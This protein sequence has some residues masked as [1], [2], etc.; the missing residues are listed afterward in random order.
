MQR[1]LQER[2]LYA[3]Q[4]DGVNGPQTR[5]AIRAFQLDQLDLDTPA[6]TV[7]GAR[8]LGAIR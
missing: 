4:I 7:N 8:R 5:A 6:L 3:G 1:S 2:G